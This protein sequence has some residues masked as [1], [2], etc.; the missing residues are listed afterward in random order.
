MNGNV[1]SAGIPFNISPVYG[2]PARTQCQKSRRRPA[3]LHPACSITAHAFRTSGSL[4]YGIGSNA[5]IRFPALWHNSLSFCAV[6]SRGYVSINPQLMCFTPNRSHMWKQIC[7]LYFCSILFLSH[8]SHIFV[9][10]QAYL[11]QIAQRPGFDKNETKRK[12]RSSLSP[13]KPIAFPMVKA[14]RTVPIPS[15]SRCPRKIVVIPAVMARQVTSN[16][17]LILE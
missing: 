16:A 6:Y 9:K 11:H 14:A 13:I 17:I 15:P 1:F 7:S 5:I 8:E 3:F 12:C 4:L 10:A 2:R